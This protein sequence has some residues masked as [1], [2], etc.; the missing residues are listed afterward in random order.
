MNIE[1][2]IYPDDGSQ[3]HTRTVAYGR[4]PIITIEPTENEDGELYVNVISSRLDIEKVA[5]L[6]AFLGETIQTGDARQRILSPDCRDENHAKC[7]LKAW[8]E[9]EDALTECGCICHDEKED[10]R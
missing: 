5:G 9:D 1:L 6:L 3:V 4:D 7:D 10:D 8:D 2:T